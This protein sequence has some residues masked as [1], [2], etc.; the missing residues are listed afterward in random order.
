TPVVYDGMVYVAVGQDPEH[1]EGQGHLWCIDPLK[2]TDGSDVSPTLAVDAEGKPLKQRR[3]QA[4]DVNAGEKEIE[5][6]DS[7]EIWHYSGGDIDGDGEISWEEEMH[8][9]CGTVAI[10]DDI[11]YISDFS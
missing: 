4:V 2:K 7:A 10:K 1:G 9:S 5:N 6:P 8:R 11:L 3:L